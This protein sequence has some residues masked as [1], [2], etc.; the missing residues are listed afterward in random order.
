MS[1]EL[2]MG[3]VTAVLMT[4]PG[5]SVP[6]ESRFICTKTKAA[7]FGGRGSVDSEAYFNLLDM[8]LRIVRRSRHWIPV[9]VAKK[10]GLERTQHTCTSDYP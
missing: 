6:N 9:A 2:V 5:L 10:Y 4:S 3:V 7:T 1:L 8:K